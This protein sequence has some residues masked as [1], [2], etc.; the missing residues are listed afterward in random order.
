MSMGRDPVQV[1]SALEAHGVSLSLDER[2]QLC[3]RGEA[4][5]DVKADARAQRAALHRFVVARARWLSQGFTL[6]DAERLA[7]VEMAGGNVESILRPRPGR[8][9]RGRRWG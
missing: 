4:P 7:R 2:G 5:E 1:L 3:A 6:E 9:L 8:P